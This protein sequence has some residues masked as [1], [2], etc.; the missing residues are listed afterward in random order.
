VIEH[1]ARSILPARRDEVPPPKTRCHR[2]G[3]RE[4]VER[5]AHSGEPLSKAA[6][7]FVEWVTRKTIPE[8]LVEQEQSVSRRR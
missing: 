4:I 3:T 7:Q 2:V 8:S 5:A 1:K 6:Q